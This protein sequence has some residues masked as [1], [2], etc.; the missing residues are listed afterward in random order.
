MDLSS[1]VDEL[2]LDVQVKNIEAERISLPT[3]NIPLG[4][5]KSSRK[6]WKRKPLSSEIR[7]HIKN[8]PNI[9]WK[10]FPSTRG[11][12]IDQEQSVRQQKLED[13]MGKKITPLPKISAEESAS[14]TDLLSKI[15]RYEPQKRI[16]LEDLA[17]HAWLAAPVESKPSTLATT[18]SSPG[19]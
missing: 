12:R 8:N 15:L 1:E 16:S 6:A 7:P 14:L 4:G 11:A 17:Q 13:A 10:P 9:F 19:L 2:P 5:K 18:L 3:V